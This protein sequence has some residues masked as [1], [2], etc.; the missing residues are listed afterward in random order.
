MVD[1]LPI[2][3]IALESDSDATSISLDRSLITD[4]YKDGDVEFFIPGEAPD[5]RI[6]LA[7][8]GAKGFVLT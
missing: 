5:K 6:M 3:Y 2:I 1:N 4:S 7:S 8:D